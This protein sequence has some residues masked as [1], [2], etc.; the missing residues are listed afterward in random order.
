M[1]YGSLAPFGATGVE[2]S[3]GSR[4]R[5]PGIIASLVSAICRPILLENRVGPAPSGA[6]Y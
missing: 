1:G 5:G 6:T 2:Y 4:I 3:L